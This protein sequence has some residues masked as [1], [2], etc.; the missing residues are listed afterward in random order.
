MDWDWKPYAVRSRDTTREPRGA[1]SRVEGWDWQLV[2][3]NRSGDLHQEGS[4][5]GLIKWEN[6]HRCAFCGGTGQRPKGARCPVCGG[7]GTVSARPPLRPCAYCNGR[8]EEQPRASITCTVCRGK[9]VVSIQEPVAFCVHCRGRGA[10]PT[11]KRP[12][13]VCKGTGVVTPRTG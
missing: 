12:C 11:S 10:E 6:T 5:M 8:G 4:A 3:V 7:K 1:G 13:I 2:K 9:G